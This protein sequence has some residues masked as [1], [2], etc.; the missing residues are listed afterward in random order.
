MQSSLTPYPGLVF[1][2]GFRTGLRTGIC[3]AAK[4]AFV[5]G[6]ILPTG[7]FEQGYCA[8][9]F[10]QVVSFHL[11]LPDPDTPLRA[12]AVCVRTVPFQHWME[13]R[14]ADLGAAQDLIAELHHGDGTH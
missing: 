6:R 7:C 12:D 1:E 14:H 10:G 2:V 11:P 13:V 8:D 4:L 9:A 3:F 5:E